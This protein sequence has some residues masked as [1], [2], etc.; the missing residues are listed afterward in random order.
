MNSKRYIE[1]INE[2]ESE[3]DFVAFDDLNHLAQ[4]IATMTG[5]DLSEVTGWVYGYFS[6]NIDNVTRA[7]SALGSIRSPRKA[8]TS[9]ANG[10]KGGRPRKER[11]ERPE[12]PSYVGWDGS[13]HGEF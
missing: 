8:Q 10:R 9:A 12:F 3:P 6:A 1:I 7:A 11:P 2:Y 4:N 5:D 13:E